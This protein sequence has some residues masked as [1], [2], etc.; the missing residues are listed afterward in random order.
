MATR[1]DGLCKL[2]HALNTTLALAHAALVHGDR[3]AFAAFDAAVRS[4]LPAHPPR[5]GH[6]LLSEA[7]LS[8]APRSVESSFRVLTEL[9]ERSHKK[10]SLVVILTDF[11]ETADALE[12]EGYLGRLARHH[13]VL[14]VALRDPI[15]STLDEALPA[16]SSLGEPELY[17]RLVLQ[18][19]AAERHLVLR[20]LT[21]LGVHTLD[22]RPEQSRAPVLSRYLELR[23]AL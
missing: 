3:I 11:V 16:G 1:V 22:L 20:R 10:R 18:D 19:L 17:R 4:W 8:L 13:V 23:R 9:L 21:R 7:T 15:L 6:A 5:R 12:L 14:L 2:D